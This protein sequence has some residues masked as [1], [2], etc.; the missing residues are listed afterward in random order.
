MISDLPG[1]AVRRGRM[2]GGDALRRRTHYVTAN[3]AGVRDYGPGGSFNRIHWRSTARRDRLI[4]K[5]F[6]LDPLSDIWIFLAGAAVGREPR[7]SHVAGQQRRIHRQR[8]GD[9]GSIF[10][11]T[12]PDGRL[13]YLRAGTRDRSARPKRAAAYEDARNAGRL[14]RRGPR[15]PGRCLVD[16]IAAT[17][18]LVDAHHRDLGQRHRMGA[19]R[20][21]LE[22][23]WS[24]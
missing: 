2:P 5:E 1:L 24:A 14:S 18:A 17:A 8:G 9:A 4:V 11:S 22:A 7:E 13:D 16:R 6:E 15:A 20:A 10:H 3:A 19:G 21:V 23:A 12:R